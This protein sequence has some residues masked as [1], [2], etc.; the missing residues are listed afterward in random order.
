MLTV[1]EPAASSLSVL[2]GGR[3]YVVNLHLGMMIKGLV[4]A[5]VGVPNPLTVEVR[6]GTCLVVII[7]EGW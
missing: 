4:V 3:L 1:I 5:T 2:Q 7:L 6:R